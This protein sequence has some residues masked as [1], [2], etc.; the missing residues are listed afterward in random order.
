MSHPRAVILVKFAKVPL[1][2]P[3][4]DA[5]SAG[6]NGIA[7]GG[8]DLNTVGAG[9]F[10]FFDR[11]QVMTRIGNILSDNDRFLI[12]PDKTYRGALPRGIPLELDTGADGPFLS[13]LGQNHP[14][15][16][17]KRQQKNTCEEQL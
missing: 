5:K 10:E 14:G 11:P 8:G 12:R 1:G 16:G 7:P 3:G 13:P 15:V 9:G 4:Y 6:L 17:T 2:I